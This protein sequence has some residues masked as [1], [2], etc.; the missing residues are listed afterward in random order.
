MKTLEEI[1]QEIETEKAKHTTPYEKDKGYD[2][3]KDFINHNKF[4]KEHLFDIDIWEC[5]QCYLYVKL[6]EKFTLEECE[7]IRTICEFAFE[8]L[9]NRECLEMIE[10]VLLITEMKNEDEIMSYITEEDEKKAKKKLEQIP[11][12]S[13]S[14]TKDTKGMLYDSKYRKYLQNLREIHI[15]TGIVDEIVENIEEDPTNIAGA[16][17]YIVISKQIEDASEQMKTVTANFGLSS[18]ERSRALSQLYSKFFSIKEISGVGSAITGFVSDEEKKE[19]DTEKDNQRIQRTYSRT[20]ELLEKASKEE[21][22]KN[23]REIART[24]PDKDIKRDV[25]EW[26]YYHNKMYYDQLE[27]KLEDLSSKKM[28]QYMAILGRAGIPIHLKD[29]QLISHNTPEEVEEILSSLPSGNYDAKTVLSILKKTTIEIARKIKK[30]MGLGYI[31]GP[32]VLEYISLYN[33]EDKKLEEME[34]SVEAISASGVNPRIFAEQPEFYWTNHQQLIHNFKVLANYNLVRM[35]KNITDFGFLL[36]TGLEEKIDRW[37]ELGFYH[38]LE[39]NLSFLNYPASSVKRFQLL[40]QMNIPVEDM[41]TVESI[42]E[43]SKFIVSDE[44]LDDYIMDYASTQKPFDIPFNAE[45]LENTDSDKTSIS[46]NGTIVSLPKIK[47][48]IREGKTM[49]NAIF[50]G[51]ILTEEEYKQ[52]KNVLTGEM[53]TKN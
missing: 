8:P 52:I 33:P 13:F 27:E 50:D 3:C 6:R 16:L 38:Y 9:G 35:I 29:I 24:I 1:K 51:L 10:I 46:L 7:R 23:A 26:I 48:G 25:L 22:I 20:I 19:T 14:L 53:S 11:D 34:A 40:K 18:R 43:S 49:W 32:K 39:Q 42:L 21:E 47:K 28:N 30:Y 44:M 45:E 17:T 5:F 12:L 36:E 37:I 31:S 41:D 15:R 4:S 2:M